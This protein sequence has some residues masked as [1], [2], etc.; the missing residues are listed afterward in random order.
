[1]VEPTWSKCV[2]AKC[3]W[4]RL[5]YTKLSGMNNFWAELNLNDIYNV[6]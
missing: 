2:V 4:L 5:T 1:M 6:W 3:Q